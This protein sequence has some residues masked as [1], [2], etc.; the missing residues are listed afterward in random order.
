MHFQIKNRERQLIISFSSSPSVWLYYIL[1]GF[2]RTVKNFGYGCNIAV[3]RKRVETARLFHQTTIRGTFSRGIHIEDERVLTGAREMICVS[4]WFLLKHWNKL[5]ASV[6][7][8]SS[9]R[10]CN[11]NSANDFSHHKL[12]LP[13]FFGLPGA[14]VAISDLI[15]GPLY[16]ARQKLG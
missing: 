15:L 1:R 7:L 8:Y 11:L 10:N 3:T 16:C 2:Y 5:I 12:R 6:D 9:G 14:L 13:R 4:R